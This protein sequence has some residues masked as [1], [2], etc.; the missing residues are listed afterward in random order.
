MVPTVPRIKSI[1]VSLTFEAPANLSSFISYPRLSRVPSAPTTSSFSHSSNTPSFPSSAPRLCPSWFLCLEPPSSS[2]LP[3]AFLSPTL[4]G[5]ASSFLPHP[6]PL[7]AGLTAPPSVPWKSE[8][9][10]F[11]IQNIAKISLRDVPRMPGL[12]H[13]ETGMLKRAGSVLGCLN[14]NFSSV[15]FELC[16]FR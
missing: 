14:S 1:L 8:I 6:Y 5:P 3:T 11:L 10:N 2:C 15:A 7:Q 16:V 13:G 12:A 4:P 9:Q